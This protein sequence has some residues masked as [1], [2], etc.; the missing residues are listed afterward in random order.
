M[1]AHTAT[2]L[3]HAELW[4]IFPNTKQAGSLVEEDYVRFDFHADRLLS[5]TEIGIIEYNI[6]SAIAWAFP[7]SVEEKSF[8]QAADMWAKAFF[9]DKYGDIV[10][11]VS[12]DWIGADGEVAKKYYSLELCGGTHVDNT[13]DIGSFVIVWQQ[14]VASGVKRITAYTG[15][16]V[17]EQIQEKNRLLSKL[18]EKLECTVA[19]LDEKVEKLISD[20]QI[21][22]SQLASIIHQV[23]QQLS[24]VTKEVQWISYQY[25]E[26]WQGLTKYANLKD[27][28]HYLKQQKMTWTLLFQDE[29]KGFLIWSSNN[30][31]KQLMNHFGR[32]GGGNEQLC[33][34]KII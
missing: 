26:L 20:Y 24:F 19:Q 10:R 13:K 3:L 30:M 4:H 34:W 14:A 28:N 17:L 5:E 31:A 32:K 9:E 12:I 22:Q 27:I 11:V 6:N 25:C 21:S 33:Q 23:I 7:V 16:K 1:R 18:A 15:P 8:T 2:H 29:S